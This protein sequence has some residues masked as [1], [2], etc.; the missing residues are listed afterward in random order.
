MLSQLA[1]C[2]DRMIELEKLIQNPHDQERVRFL[3]G[4]DLLPADA[5]LKLEE[6]S[7]LYTI[8]YF[9]NFAKK[10]FQ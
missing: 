4:K 6:V 5:Q 8:S 3:E 2:Q 7:I 10:I 9:E 1:Q